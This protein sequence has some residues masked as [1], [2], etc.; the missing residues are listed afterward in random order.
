MSQ[1]SKKSLYA[2]LLKTVSRKFYFIGDVCGSVVNNTLTS[3]GY[4][5]CYQN[6]I[7]CNHSIP[8]PR[9][10]ALKIDFHDFDL[11]NDSSCR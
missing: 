9:D 8:I 5:H 1:K 2:F 10:M 3:P 7:Y 11:Q 4:P 6:S